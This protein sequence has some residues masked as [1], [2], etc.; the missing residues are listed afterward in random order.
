MTLLCLYEKFNAWQTQV[1]ELDGQGGVP[2]VASSP[3]YKSAA[4]C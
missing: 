2:P 4:D 1:I 3:R